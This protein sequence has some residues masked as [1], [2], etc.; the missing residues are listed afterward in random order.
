MLVRWWIFIISG[1][2]LVAMVALA[3]SFFVGVVDEET[4]LESTGR[5]NIGFAVH[6]LPN[7]MFPVNPVPD[8]L[9]FL[10]HFI[11]FIEIESSFSADFTR[12]LGI[13]YSYTASKRF[14]ITYG[15]IGGVNPVVYEEE[16]ILNRMSGNVSGDYLNLEA[17][18]H[19]IDLDVYMEILNNFLYHNEQLMEASDLFSVSRNF[20]AELVIEF[21][22]TIQTI[23][24]NVRQTT[25]RGY[26]LP[27]GQ[28][29]F[30]L[31]A[32]GSPGFTD[33]VVITHDSAGVS[34]VQWMILSAM[35][36]V[37]AG[38]IVFGVSRLTL[39]DNKNLKKANSI[40]KKYAT[41]IILSPTPMDLS[42]YQRMQVEDFEEILKL[43]INLSKHITCNKDDYQASFYIIVDSLAYYYEITYGKRKSKYLHFGDMDD[44]VY[45]EGG[46]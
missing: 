7:D 39:E 40:I 9:H 44:D 35:F 27:V 1:L 45:D 14:I 5:N 23:P 8:N 34:L 2:I 29:V 19:I 21:T 31:E 6:Y 15:G 42:D 26:R 43:S 30:T 13:S 11:D 3:V 22:Y 4:A 24:V 32:F 36:L 10:R 37:G 28:N 33:T 41:E 46:E 25:T 12:E 38:G 18:T 20:S 16:I 17:D